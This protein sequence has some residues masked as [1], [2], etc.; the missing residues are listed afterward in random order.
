MVVA[1][2]AARAVGEHDRARR[3]QH[4]CERRTATR[5]VRGLGVGRRLVRAIAADREQ[6]ILVQLHPDRVVRVDPRR[7]EPLGL[8]VV[9]ARRA[10]RAAAGGTPANRSTARP[11]RGHDGRDPFVERVEAVE[12]RPVVARRRD[13]RSGRRPAAPA[14]RCRCAA[15]RGSAAGTARTP[16]ARP[17]RRRRPAA[18][19]AHDACGHAPDGGDADAARAPGDEALV[20][21]HGHDLGL[22]DLDHAAQADLVQQPERRVVGSSGAGTP[23]W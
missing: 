11:S 16:G 20:D 5:P 19:R 21:E 3:R 22:V 6:E 14:S 9:D 10:R 7:R 1:V 2:V 8:A 12:H 18:R 17:A 15:A 23:R 13:D 4:G